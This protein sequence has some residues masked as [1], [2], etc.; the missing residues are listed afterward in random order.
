MNTSNQAPVTVEQREDA[1]VAFLRVAAKYFESRPINGED[2]AHWSNVAN[3]A[4]C[5]RIA[6]RLAAPPA[7]T[8]PDAGAE[9]EMAAVERAIDR[10]GWAE[11]HAF[12]AELRRGQDIYE[13]AG[14]FMLRAIKALFGVKRADPIT[15]YQDAARAMLATSEQERGS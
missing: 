12:Q 11:I 14:G 6:N 3:A 9:G 15:T 10:M 1:D 2:M 13:D 5:R 4:A 7:S 8:Y